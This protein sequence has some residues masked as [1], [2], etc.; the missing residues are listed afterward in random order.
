MTPR[1]FRRSPGRVRRRLRPH[2]PL[3]GQR[4]AVVVKEIVYHIGTSGEA[5]GK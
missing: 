5:M 1:L 4:I 3:T 2:I